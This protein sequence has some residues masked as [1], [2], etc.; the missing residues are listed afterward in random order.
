[1]EL[2]ARWGLSLRGWLTLFGISLCAILT[3]RV[4]IFPF[5]A[6]NAPLA[7]DLLVVEGWIHK[8]A[9]TAAACQIGRQNY[10]RVFTTG[11]P[12]QGT[13]P[14][15][16]DFNTSASVAFYRLIDAGVPKHLLQEVP[17]RVRDRD[18][19]YSAALALGEWLEKNNLRPTNLNVVTESVHARRT[20]LLFQ[21]ALGPHIRVGIISIPP[22][23]YS[24]TN[25]WRYSEGTKEVISETAAY[26][27][28]RFFFWP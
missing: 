28:A 11:G 22:D 8:S 17:C 7:S 23:E 19:T 3:I 15:S 10:Q 5:L 12:V 24:A 13:G 21:K 25:W 14:Y 6:V 2:R 9:I 4:G 20:R 18:R 27:Y 16:N 26:L 1:V